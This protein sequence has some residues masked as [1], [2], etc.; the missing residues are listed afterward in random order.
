MH[1]NGLVC[2]QQ[3]NCINNNELIWKVSQ[4]TLA[5]GSHFLMRDQINT[6]SGNISSYIYRLF[7]SCIPISRIVVV[8]NILNSI[9][10]IA[11]GHV[12][13]SLDASPCKCNIRFRSEILHRCSIRK[14]GDFLFRSFTTAKEIVGNVV[15]VGIFSQLSLS[16]NTV[17][18]CPSPAPNHRRRLLQT[19]P[20]PLHTIE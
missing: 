1:M 16:T 17:P 20:F 3:A 7:C 4:G 8:A 11:R 18:Q 10:K 15:I 14:R 12:G 5:L 19:T 6:R 2:V 9:I 13:P